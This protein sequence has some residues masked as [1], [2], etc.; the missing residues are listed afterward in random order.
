MNTL[1]KILCISTFATLHV[2]AQE[3]EMRVYFS[4]DLLAFADGKSYGVNADHIGLTLQ[5]IH[6]LVKM[7]DG[8]KGANGN[9]AGIFMFQ[10]VPH[11]TRSLRQLEAEYEKNPQKVTAKQRVQ[12]HACLVE[13]V[14]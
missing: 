12:L 1:T 14:K 10:G 4:S 7:Q 3:A 13:T 5:L 2:H 8:L 11:T 9:V 6:E